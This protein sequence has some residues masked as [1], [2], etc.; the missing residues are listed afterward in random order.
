MLSLVKQAAPAIHI[1]AFTAVEIAHF[2]DVSEMTLRD[3]LSA[4]AD[5]GLGSLPG[6]GAEVFSP[7]IRESL[8]PEK[9][10][11]RGWLDVM[12][13]AHDLGLRSN[14]SMLYGH[15]ETSEEL[16][17]HML[18]LRELQ[19]KTGGF[20]TFIPLAY[21][22]MNT[23]LGGEEFTTA[24][25]DLKALAIGRLM[26]DNFDHV[27]AFWIMLG[28]NLAQ[29]SLHFGVDDLDGTVGEEKITHDAGAQTPQSLTVSRLEHLIREAG[30]APVR[31][32]TVYDV[33]G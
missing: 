4:L 30:R 14:A 33:V 25:Q 13:T 29:V 32:N 10:S 31:R 20:M 24:I 6:G 18:A 23:E 27:K 12:E 15:I 22:P 16:V 21:H 17:D 8:C 1:Q 3:V 2:A 5:A 9:L 19:D 7:R 11:P 26:L 28:T